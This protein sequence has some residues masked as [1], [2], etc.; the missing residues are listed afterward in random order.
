MGETFRNASFYDRLRFVR[1]ALSGA[2][3]GAAVVGI[4]C[5][6]FKIQPHDVYDFAGAAAGF[7]LIAAIKAAH[8]NIG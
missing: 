4:I 5:M 7:T 3:A 6:V 8:F 2:I 1:L